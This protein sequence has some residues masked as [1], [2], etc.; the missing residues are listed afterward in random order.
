MGKKG[1]WRAVG[2]ENEG[3]RIGGGGQVDVKWRAGGWEVEDI[4]EGGRRRG[5][6]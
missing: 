2:W 6:P 4:G 1:R 5:C 3:R